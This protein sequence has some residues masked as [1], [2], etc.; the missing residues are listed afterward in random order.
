VTNQN[1]TF[2][3]IGVRVRAARAAAGI[4]RKRLSALADVSERYLNELENGEANV[5]VGVLARVARALGVEMLDLLAPGNGGQR[6]PRPL[7][8]PLAAMIAG[9]S[10]REQE[11]AL[12]HLER[13]LA[14]RRK[15]I[16]GIALLGLRGAGKTTLGGMLAQRHGLPFLS[17]TREIE[18]RAGMSLNDL[19]NLGGPEAYRTLENDVVREIASRSDRIVLETAGGIVSNAPALDMILSAFKTVWLKASPTE[20]LQRV[21]HQGDMRPMQATPKALEHLESLLATREPEYA[22]ADCVLDTTGR[23]AAACVDE[24]EVIA[25]PAVMQ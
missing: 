22:R 16:K 2:Q 11:A 8:P 3:I 21:I 17:V 5:S 15:S 4:S 23:T 25:G 1:Q 20:H 7:H 13:F 10:L 6:P 18:A 24:L 9:M 14:E 19:F 12:P